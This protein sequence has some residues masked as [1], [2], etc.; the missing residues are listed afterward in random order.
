M[1]KRTNLYNVEVPPFGLPAINCFSVN[2]DTETTK[3]LILGFRG[4]E[5]V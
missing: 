5:K 4:P 1:L 2:I 3:H